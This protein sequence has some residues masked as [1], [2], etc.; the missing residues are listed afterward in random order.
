[1]KFDLEEEQT[2]FRDAVAAFARR[3]LADG[4][5]ERAHSDDYPWQVAGLMAEQGLIGITVLL[6]VVGKFCHFL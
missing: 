1:M 6:G 4:A 5:R 2:A 3:H